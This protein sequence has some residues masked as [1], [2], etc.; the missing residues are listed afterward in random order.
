MAE[1]TPARP[2]VWRGAVWLISGLYFLVPMIAAI[3]YTVRAPGGGFSLSAYA[4]IPRSTG[5]PASLLLSLELSVATIA[6]L[7]LVLVPAAIAVRL[8][9]PKLRVL[10]EVICTLPLVVPPIA[11]VSGISTVLQWGPD[12][13]ARTPFYQ[14][15]LAIQNPS[16]PVV[17]V[18]ADVVLALP[19]AYRTLDTGLRGLDVPTLLEAARSCGAS[20]TRAV[21]SAL[22]PN[23]RGALLNAAFLTVA[24]VLGEFTM[25]QLLGFQ[26]F[27]VWIVTSSA[28]QPQVSVAASIIS[29]LV[30]WALLLVLAAL[31]RRP[32]PTK[33]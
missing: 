19:L 31:V 16:F 10:I 30:T 8:G 28:D 33:E 24:L 11:F 29:L 17:L 9:G 4:A 22:L 3:I 2:R 12:Y 15:I 13:L 21:L 6:V 14:T 7:A 18:L 20:R 27:S 5:F 32:R 26:P 25:A 23:L 1:L